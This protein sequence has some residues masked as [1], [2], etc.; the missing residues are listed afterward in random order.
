ME[1]WAKRWE[2]QTDWPLVHLHYPCSLPRTSAHKCLLTPFVAVKPA[3]RDGQ[4]RFLRWKQ[5]CIYLKFVLIW[6]LVGWWKTQGNLS[7]VGEGV[8][9]TAEPLVR[10]SIP[11]TLHL[12]SDGNAARRWPRPATR[13]RQR[14]HERTCGPVMSPVELN[15]MFT[16][17]RWVWMEKLWLHAAALFQVLEENKW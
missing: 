11:G 8:T 7:G 13:E 16:A 17:I 1:T 2:Q 10:S 6:N 3:T 14:R 9:A 12:P 15:E 5:S 4:P